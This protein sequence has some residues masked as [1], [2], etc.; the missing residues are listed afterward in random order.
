MITFPIIHRILSVCLCLGLGTLLCA[1]NETLVIKGS[2]T[3]GAKLMPQLKE[4]YKVTHPDVI[5]EIAAEG[6]STGV[7]AII[8]NKAD[9][10]MS[11]R[12]I[13]DS[14]VAQARLN[15]VDMQT[16]TVAYDG[17]AIVVNE[18]NPIEDLS[19][20]E[21]ELI[22]TGMARDWGF[23]GGKPGRISSYTRNT[24][25]G[26]YSSFQDL[27]MRKRDYGANSQKMA[28][29]EQIASEVANNPNGIGYVA[30]AYIATPGV[31]VVTIDG[32][33]PRT[34]DIA[35]GDYP[36]ARPLFYLIDDNTI[37]DRTRD[38]IDFTLSPQGQ[39]IVEGVYFVPLTLE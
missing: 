14:E 32:A 8:D 6:S 17:I 1:Q 11:S 26:T 29:N 30:L 39:R 19:R 31:K 34:Q 3:L 5:F 18:N 2:D 7:A 36:Y 24:S 21:V 35:A 16:I 9:I 25:S 37:S 22:F 23:V 13:K 10:G 4:A 28:G 38:F 27:A 15:G 12:D 20:R 33:Y